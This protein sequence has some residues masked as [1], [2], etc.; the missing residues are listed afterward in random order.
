MYNETTLVI[1][2]YVLSIS[3]LCIVDIVGSLLDVNVM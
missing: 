1:H 3:I 2:L